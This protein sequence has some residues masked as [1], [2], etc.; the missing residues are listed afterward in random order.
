MY[1]LNLGRNKLPWKQITILRQVQGRAKS[2]TYL[3]SDKTV[4]D[5]VIPLYAP[6]D[7]IEA[8]RVVK[9]GQDGGL[10]MSVAS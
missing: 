2:R 5:I 7:A 6:A 1:N 8:N 9:D 3:I 4:T 10:Q